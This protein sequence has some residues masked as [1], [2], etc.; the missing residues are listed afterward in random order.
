[1]ELFQSLLAGTGSATFELI[2]GLYDDQNANST[3]P[4]LRYRGIPTYPSPHAFQLF[5]TYFV[6]EAPGGADPFPLF[7]DPAQSAKVTWR[8]CPEV[9]RR[10]FDTEP[11][12]CVT[13]TGGTVQKV[14]RQNDS[15]ALPYSRP[16]KDGATPGG[17]MV[18]TTQT[19]LQLQDGD[20][21]E[22]FSLRTE[23]GVTKPTPLPE[24]PVS[25]AL[26]WRALFPEGAPALDMKHAYFAVPLFPE[27]DRMV[28]DAMTQPLA[29]EQTLDYFERLSARPNRSGSLG[30]VLIHNWDLLLSEIIHPTE[31]QDYTVLYTRPEFAQRQAHRLWDQ[32]AASGRLSNLRRV[33]FL[34]ADQHQQTAYTKSYGL[35][36]CWIPFEQYRQRAECERSLEAVSKALISGGSAI[37]SGPPWLKDVCSRVALR[38]LASDPIAETAG[39]RMHRAILPKA[40]VNPEA[41]LY[42][43]QKM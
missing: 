32:T 22:E 15:A 42:L 41:T 10:F 24:R 28:E 43:V 17:R 8:P 11:G 23:W 18:G 35:L 5:S 40:R 14:T 30:N 9:P 25:P 38:V 4:L 27:D 37:L 29:L 33:A 34:Q 26:T 7:M 19:V 21:R 36:Y 3:P 16:R 20:R 13:V 1:V 31:D 39:V 2:R 12:L 6:P